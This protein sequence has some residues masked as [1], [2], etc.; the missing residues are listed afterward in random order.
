MELRLLILVEPLRF[1]FELELDT[2]VDTRSAVVWLVN[3][4]PR[5]LSTLPPGD[6]LK[7]FHSSE[8]K[9]CME[10]LGSMGCGK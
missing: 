3:R 5:T 4:S 1:C 6:M 10:G 7:R 9:P 8:V 2:R